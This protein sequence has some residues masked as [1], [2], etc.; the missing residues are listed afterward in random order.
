M[1][2]EVIAPTKR[3]RNRRAASKRGQLA[4]Q[5]LVM[6]AVLVGATGCQGTLARKQRTHGAFGSVAYAPPS[7]LPAGQARGPRF[8][9]AA[10]PGK[11]SEIQQAHY[12]AGP[13]YVQAAPAYGPTYAA[14]PPGHPAYYHDESVTDK[15]HR[16]WHKVP[17]LGIE[18]GVAL[19]PIPVPLPYLWPAKKC[20]TLGAPVPVYSAPGYGPP[21]A[22]PLPAYH[23]GYGPGGGDCHD[24][25]APAGPSFETISRN[26][27]MEP[28]H[29]RL[30]LA[31][32]TLPPPAWAARTTASIAQVPPPPS[33]DG[34]WQPI[35]GEP[36]LP[37]S[38]GMEPLTLPRPG[39]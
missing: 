22:Y 1:R 23:P 4:G 37:E 19:I 33:Y 21:P 3:Y 25:C 9:A 28:V 10:D 18:V 12:Q 11:K 5:A 29:E 15:I 17:K 26:A 16:A 6:L 14:Y 24:P 30:Q 13:A 38:V 27:P 20:P 2:Q 35:Q 8:A 34:N 36:D 32:V 7:T 39:E 31:S